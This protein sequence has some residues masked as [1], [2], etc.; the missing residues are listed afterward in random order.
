MRRFHENSA[1]RF[2]LISSF[3]LFKTLDL[4]EKVRRARNNDNGFYRRK[5][6]KWNKRLIRLSLPSFTKLFSR[7]T[8]QSYLKI[9]QQT[10]FSSP[11]ILSFPRTIRELK[12][13]RNKLPT[14][15]IGAPSLDKHE[16]FQ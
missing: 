4:S 2:A 5:D 8:Y 15:L 3:V 1:E 6:S 12:T 11:F 14:S 16:I 13:E 9:D 7:H 10:S